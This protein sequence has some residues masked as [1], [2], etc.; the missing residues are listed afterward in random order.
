MSALFLRQICAD[1]RSLKQYVKGDVPDLRTIRQNLFLLER[2][3]DFKRPDHYFKNHMASVLKDI[4]DIGGLIFRGVDRITDD[5]LSTKGHQIIVKQGKF[6]GFQEIVARMPP[7]VLT[8]FALFRSFG[9]PAYSLEHITAYTSNYIVP[10]LKGTTLLSPFYP[11]L[12]S[13]I[14]ERCGLKDLHIHL[15]GTTEFDFVWQD[16]LAQPERFYSAFAPGVTKG[17]V[18][19]QFEQIEPGLTAHRVYRRIRLAGLLRHRLCLMLYAGK[20]LRWKEFVRMIRLDNFEKQD[21]FNRQKHPA[22]VC[23]GSFPIPSEFSETLFFIHAF[24]YLNRG[25]PDIFGRGLHLYLLLYGFLNQ[26]VVHQVEQNGFE[27]F[28]KV[29][30][31]ETRASVESEYTRRFFQ[32]AGKTGLDAGLI[33]GRFAPKSTVMENL[34]LLD[35]IVRGY[36]RYQNDPRYNLFKDRSTEQRTNFDLNLVAHFIKKPDKRKGCTL[37]VRHHEL[38]V[39]LECQAKALLAARQHSKYLKHHLKGFDAAANELHASAEVFAPVFRYLR[40]NGVT[41]FTFH[42]GED[43]IHLL[44][45]IRAVHEALVFLDLS[46]GNRVGHANAIGIDPGYWLAAM[47]GEIAISRGEWLDNLVFLYSQ[48]LRYKKGWVALSALE[49]EIASHALQ[50]YGRK[51]TVPHLLVA[52]YNMRKLDPLVACRGFRNPYDALNTES[53]EEWLIAGNELERNRAAFRLYIEYHSWSCQKK[54]EEMI[55]VQHDKL[56]SESL[57]RQLQQWI[58]DELNQRDIAIESM[59][60]SNLRISF[61]QQYKDHHIWRWLGIADQPFET[62][63]SVCLASDDPGIFATN[64]RNE[65]SHIYEHLIYQYEMSGE[66]AQACINRLVSNAEAFKF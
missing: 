63:P 10:N 42:V 22:A 56:V 41:N 36:A 32:L 16:A 24:R 59:P 57:L 66:E 5:F 64:I 31:N 35:K 23:T 44:S 34:K 3:L 50:I 54:S 39:N 12:E 9:S 19:E 11:R 27:Q 46:Q 4:D 14:R 17:S 40:R 7:L 20:P 45:G 37:L 33:E 55:L 48:M 51:G 28:Q 18:K 53:W 49:N 61:Y 43:F 8:A 47:K 58:V 2:A 25:A 26:F 65:Y 29:S 15:N 62:S 60:T 52:A 21:N 6:G 38:R 1:N 13:V 30:D